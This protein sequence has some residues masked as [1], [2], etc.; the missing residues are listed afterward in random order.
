MTANANVFLLE[1]EVTNA[2]LLAA[3]A[4]GAKELEVRNLVMGADATQNSLTRALSA[5][6]VEAVLIECEIAVDE[7]A[8]A[9]RAMADSGRCRTLYVALQQMEMC[10]SNALCYFLRKAARLRTLYVVVGA[11]F[12]RQYHQVWTAIGACPTLQYLHYND[13][14]AV[15]SEMPRLL[16][17]TLAMPRIVRQLKTL[18]ISLRSSNDGGDHMTLLAVLEWLSDMMRLETLCITMETQATDADIAAMQRFG[19]D[20]PAKLQHFCVRHGEQHTVVV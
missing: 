5:P 3:E 12:M 6:A 4:S 19:R 17:R 9:L 7:L 16:P 20:P 1:N 15:Y 8:E 13:N 18:D 11:M 14:G 10:V 2:Q